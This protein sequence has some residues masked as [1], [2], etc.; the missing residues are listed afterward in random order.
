MRTSQRLA[1][2]IIRLMKAAPDYAESVMREG[3]KGL[4]PE[5]AGAVCDECSRMLHVMR[6]EITAFA[7]VARELY[8]D[9]PHMHNKE[10]WEELFVW[11]ERWTA[12]HGTAGSA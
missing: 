4:G 7:R 5:M 3:V 11:F 1:Q 10:A 6:E 9:D 2:D 12:D 8:A